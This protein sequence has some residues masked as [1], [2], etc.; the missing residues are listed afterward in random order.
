MNTATDAETQIH[1]A[2][3][4]FFAFRE[5]GLFMSGGMMVKSDLQTNGAQ[6]AGKQHGGKDRAIQ[7]F[8]SPS[9][10]FL[11]LLAVAGGKIDGAANENQ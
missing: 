6:R 1:H 8:G 4:Q 5:Q 3:K 11:L 10:H 2:H 9:F 7:K